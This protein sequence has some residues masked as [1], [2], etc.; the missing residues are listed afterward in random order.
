MH[1]QDSSSLNS[2]LQELDLTV[3]TEVIN[4]FNQSV[5]ISVDYLVQVGA[6][7]LITGGFPWLAI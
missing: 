3:G 7:D 1:G 6:W 2:A 4:I 5:C